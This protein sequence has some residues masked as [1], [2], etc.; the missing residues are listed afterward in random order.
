MEFISQSGFLK[1]VAGLQ[2]Q[3]YAPNINSPFLANVRE[4]F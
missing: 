1:K 4:K 3:F 2:M